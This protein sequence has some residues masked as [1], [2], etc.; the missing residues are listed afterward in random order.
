MLSVAN[1]LFMLGLVMLNGVKLIVTNNVDMLSVVMLN[2]VLLSV[3]MLSV[4]TPSLY[5]KNRLYRIESSGNGPEACTIKY[6]GFVIYRK[7]AV[8][9][10]GSCPSYRK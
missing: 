7:W 9:I 4:V 3:V 8:F 10:V 6:Y 1:N 5:T 2:V